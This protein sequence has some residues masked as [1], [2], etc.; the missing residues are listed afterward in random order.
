MPENQI[1]YWSQTNPCDRWRFEISRDLKHW[2]LATNTT[3]FAD[4]WMYYE[5]S[6]SSQAVEF[7]RMRFL[8]SNSPC[9]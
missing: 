3:I 2:E 9:N 6:A 8:G 5:T 4:G 1:Q 7:V